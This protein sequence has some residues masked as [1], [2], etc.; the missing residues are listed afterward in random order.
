MEILKK[1]FKTEKDERKPE[2]LEQKEKEAIIDLLMLAIYA[3]NHLSLAEDKILKEEFEK[4][5]WVSVTG[6]DIYL[7][8]ATARARSA[9]TSEVARKEFL[10]FIGERLTSR[11]AR[12]KALDLL[13]KVFY[14]DGTTEKEKEFT[15]AVKAAL[16]D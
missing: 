8:E 12:G 14:S 7:A 4:M 16:A 9:L 5:R 2:D 15:E 13:S 10:E 6:I 3:D 1:L 11:P